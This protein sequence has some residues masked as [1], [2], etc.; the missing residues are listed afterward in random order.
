MTD[1]VSVIVDALVHHGW[2]REA[3]ADYLAGYADQVRRMTAQEIRS[4][5]SNQGIRSGSGEWMRV[6]SFIEEDQY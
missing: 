3:A 1:Y 5:A 4:E 6:A 2:T